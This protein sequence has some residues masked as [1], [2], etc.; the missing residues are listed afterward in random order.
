MWCALVIGYCLVA[1][2][3][4]DT[5]INLKLLSVKN[6]KKII[7][8]TTIKRYINKIKKINIILIINNINSY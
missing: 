7:L 6:I 3:Y 8:M 1:E 2:N 5:F 4:I